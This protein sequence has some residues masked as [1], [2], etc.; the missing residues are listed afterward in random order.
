MRRAEIGRQFLLEL[1]DR[2]A[3]DEVAALE[4]TFHRL[5]DLGALFLELRGK[6]D[7]TDAPAAGVSVHGRIS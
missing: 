4:Y 6:I 7:V 5:H 3:A 1:A 2:R